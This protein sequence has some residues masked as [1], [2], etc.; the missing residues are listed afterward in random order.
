[1]NR[2]ATTL[3][4]ALLALACPAAA[5][6]EGTKSGASAPRNCVA[7]DTLP[8]TAS[9]AASATPFHRAPIDSFMQRPSGTH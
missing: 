1:M 3:A 9:N 2:L 8:A 5:A 6:H 4:A 7:A